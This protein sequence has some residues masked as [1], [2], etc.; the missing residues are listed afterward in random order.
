M[1]S[2]LEGRVARLEGEPGDGTVGDTD[3]AYL[4]DDE[5]TIVLWISSRALAAHPEA[6]DDRREEFKRKAENIEAGIIRQAARLASPDYGDFFEACRSN[7][8]TKTGKDDY[9][10][11][12]SV[13]SGDTWDFPDIM[14]R[15]AA[16]WARPDVQRLIGA[17]GAAAPGAGKPAP[18]HIYCFFNDWEHCR[19]PELLPDDPDGLRWLARRCSDCGGASA[20][21]AKVGAA[22]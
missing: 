4:T 20:A 10:P 9:V 18:L 15:R 13:E 17:A 14:Q 19:K 5:L 7:W 12:V 22:P 8:K 16:L 11:P 1:I 3:L 21:S 6:D 2:A